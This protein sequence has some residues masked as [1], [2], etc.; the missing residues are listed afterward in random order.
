MISDYTSQQKALVKELEDSFA[1]GNSQSTVVNMQNDYLNDNQV[2]LTSVA[3]I[4]NGISEI[5]T[6]NIIEP[7]QKLEPEHYF[8][9]PESMHLTI[10]NVRTI[11]NPPLFSESDIEKVNELFSKII[12]QFPA[13]EFNVEDILLF[14]TSISIMAYSDDTLQKLVMA[15]DQGLNSIGMPDN[16]KYIS[17]SIFW[18]NITVCRFTKKPSDLFIETVKKMRNNKIGKFKIEKINLITS[19]VVIS[20]GSK[21][22]IAEY[23][24]I[25]KD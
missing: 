8:F 21:N 7:L 18:G 4:P 9:P 19:N 14:P 11:H 10:K 13:F 6:K 15:L 20:P 16:K 12:P 2:C 17:D 3:F 24:L 22:I 23:K 5:I 1:R 25:Q